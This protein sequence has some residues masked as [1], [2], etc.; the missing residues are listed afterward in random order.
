M[1]SS[2]QDTRLLS[3]EHDIVLFDY[4]YKTDKQLGQG[5]FGTVYAGRRLED[6]WPVA[7]KYIDRRRVPEW[8]E[9]RLGE[10]LENNTTDIRSFSLAAIVY[11]SKLYYCREVNA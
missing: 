6:K 3:T 5:G 7:V 11:H 8:S 1:K 10:V 9:V 4:Q 2:I